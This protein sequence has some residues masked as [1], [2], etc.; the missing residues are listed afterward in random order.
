ME[1]NVMK[2]IKI[3]ITQVPM[4]VRDTPVHR[5][6]ELMHGEPPMILKDGDYDHLTQVNIKSIEYRVFRYVTPY[7]AN[8]EIKYLI[9]ADDRMMVD[10]LFVLEKNLL[11][12]EFERRVSE[13]IYETTR[14]IKRLTWWKR[15]FKKF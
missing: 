14:N 8:G 4:D 11:E 1:G 10:R 9:K 15:L 3:D 6:A 2:V 13:A 7:S 12:K 5:F